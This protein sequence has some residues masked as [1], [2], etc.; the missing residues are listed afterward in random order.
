MQICGMALCIEEVSVSPR[1]VYAV[2]FSLPHKQVG[3]TERPCLGHCQPV[4]LVSNLEKF[5]VGILESLVYLAL[6]VVVM[7]AT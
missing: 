3:F 1:V 7:S 2:Q 5:V 6:P 4:K